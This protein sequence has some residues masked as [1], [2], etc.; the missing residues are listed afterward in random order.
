MRV[1]QTIMAAIL[2]FRLVTDFFT[3]GMEGEK[4]NFIKTLISTGIMVWLLFAGG[5][6]G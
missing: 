4:V 5:F 2:T 6:F 1:P 3:H